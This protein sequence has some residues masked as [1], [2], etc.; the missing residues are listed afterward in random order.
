M[1]RTKIETIATQ[2]RSPSALKEAKW[3]NQGNRKRKGMSQVPF[4]L[5]SV[6]N[7]NQVL[8][9]DPRQV[10]HLPTEEGS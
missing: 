1:K 9:L 2:Q 6:P 3:R 7:N 8:I 10:I 5:S 4:F